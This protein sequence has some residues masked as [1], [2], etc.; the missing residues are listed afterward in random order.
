LQTENKYV[1][2]KPTPAGIHTAKTLKTP[3]QGHSPAFTKR[4]YKVTLQRRNYI[5]KKKSKSRLTIF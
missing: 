4:I 2:V 1:I 5:T 3:F